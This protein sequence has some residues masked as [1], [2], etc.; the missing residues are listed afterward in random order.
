MAKALAVIYDEKDRQQI[1][2]WIKLAPLETRVEIKGPKRT[3]PQN[4][5]MWSML[6]D[7]VVQKKTI[8][9]RTFK[10]DE[11]K[12]IFMEALGREQV[13][14]PTLDGRSFFSIGHSSS[15]LEKQEMSDMIEFMFAWGAENDVVW[16]D[17]KLRS[18]EDMR[19]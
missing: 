17:P 3:L 9:G 12:A 1:I 14:L 4:D 11:W 6:T 19:R 10:T 8:G 16:S 2:D 18:Y 5:K 15:A 7:I 13:A